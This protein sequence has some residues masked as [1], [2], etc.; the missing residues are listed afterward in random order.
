MMDTV[1]LEPPKRPD[2]L[3]VTS[4]TTGKDDTPEVVVASSPTDADR[5]VRRWWSSPAR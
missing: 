5:A 2:G 3:P 4:I 1:A